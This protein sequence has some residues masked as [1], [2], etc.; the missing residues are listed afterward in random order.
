[1]RLV[2]DTV[3]V[4]AAP[5]GPDVQA[6]AQGGGDGAARLER[7]ASETSPFKPADDLAPDP[8]PPCDVRLPK[9]GPGADDTDDRPDAHVVHAQEH[10]DRVFTRAVL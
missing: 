8:G 1:M 7:E 4:A 2:E 5:A 6:D 3:K 10:G 9:A